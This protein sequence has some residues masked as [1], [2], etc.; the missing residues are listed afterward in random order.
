LTDNLQ[1]LTDFLSE[2][3][4]A[5]GVYIGKLVYPRKPIQD[6]ADDKAHLDE[7]SAKVLEYV[8]ATTDHKFMLNR[9]IT[10]E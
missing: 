1:Q 10:P 6:D 9:V 2:N 5:T 7:E 4:Q 8:N 3:T